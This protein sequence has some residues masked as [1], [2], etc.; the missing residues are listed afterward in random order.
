MSK[1]SSLAGKRLTRKEI[2]AD[3]I[4]DY[5]RGAYTWV[6]ENR[7]LLVAGVG[8]LL[9]I[10]AVIY[11]VQGLRSSLDDE[12]QISFADAMKVFLAP[13]SGQAPVVE[14]G[15]EGHDHL[16]A[17]GLV[18][19]TAAERDQQ[20]LEAFQAIVDGASG[21]VADFA[22]F[23]AAV[24]RDRLGDSSEAEK[25]LRELASRVRTPEVTALTRDYLASI[26]E[27]DGNWELVIESLQAMVEQSDTH[28]PREKVLYR[29]ARS[30]ESAGKK[31]EALE[32]YR[33]LI[34]EFPQHSNAREISE[35]ITILG[36]L[37]GEKPPAEDAATDEAS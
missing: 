29:L 30:L 23:Y 24:S 12:L 25:E 15:H 1:E 34:A 27:R 3:P 17:G 28:Y 31:T 20:A 16:P 32:E 14:P 36:A 22:A 7:N 9:L 6:T 2:Q 18:F 37:L 5:L 10:V 13:T 35:R 4:R 8:I 26:G 21:S 11:V 33:K 19:E